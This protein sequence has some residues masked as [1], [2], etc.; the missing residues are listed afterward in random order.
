MQFHSAPSALSN[1]V[2]FA[3]SNP[4]FTLPLL[5]MGLYIACGFL[6]AKL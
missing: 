1:A 3:Q 4:A 6:A 2:E 5:V